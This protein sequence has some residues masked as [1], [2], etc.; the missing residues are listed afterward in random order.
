MAAKSFHLWTEDEL[1]PNDVLTSSLASLRLTDEAVVTSENTVHMVDN[2]KPDPTFPE[3]TSSLLHQSRQ[4]SDISIATK[5]EPLP[6]DQGKIK[7]L[8]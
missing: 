5:P 4:Q 7:V 3:M 1:K 6:A 8:L 2:P